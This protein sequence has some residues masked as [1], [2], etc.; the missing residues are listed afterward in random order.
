MEQQPGLTPLPASPPA[1]RSAATK[2]AGAVGR[3]PYASLAVIIV[4][5]IVV[6][7]MYV[8]YHGFL[9]LG[10]FAARGSRRPERKPASRKEPPAADPPQESGDPETERLIAAI[11]TK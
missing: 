5:T 2:L 1:K 4:L 6:I 8:Y 3:N 7:S 10:P 9:W 11:N